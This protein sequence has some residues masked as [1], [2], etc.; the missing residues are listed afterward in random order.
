MR[1]PQEENVSKVL[2]AITAVV[3]L[4]VGLVPVSAQAVKDGGGTVNIH[5]RDYCDPASFNAVLG[6]GACVRDVTPG[7]ITFGGFLAELGAEKS[8]GAWRFAPNPGKA[9]ENDQLVI[10]NL[11]GELHTFTKVKKFGGGFVAPLNAASGNPKPAPECATVV[12]GNLVPQPPG[13]DNLFIPAGG[14]A[15]HAS[16]DKLVRYQCCIHPWMRTT[17]QSKDSK[18]QGHH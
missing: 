15:T 3:L 9:D 7:L 18:N 14:T 16:F 11:G 5:L 8:V 17:I 6:D 1:S 10:T 13:P 2:F 12:D 4:F